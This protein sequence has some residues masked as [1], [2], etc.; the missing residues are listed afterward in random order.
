M[1][2]K[3][4]FASFRYPLL[5]PRTLGFRLRKSR[6]AKRQGI[7][8]LAKISEEARNCCIYEGSKDRK[9]IKDFEE[10]RNC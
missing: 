5:V 3:L 10:L 1:Q 9:E 7:D 8:V 6:V 2:A 4:F